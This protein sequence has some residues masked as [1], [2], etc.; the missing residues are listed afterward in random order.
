MTPPI[1]TVN[2]LTIAFGDAAPVVNGVSFTLLA[3]E[4]LG[5]LGLSGSGKSLTALALL[6]LLPAGAKVTAG[7]AL[8][9]LK[10]GSE[11]DLLQLDQGGWREI[12]GRDISLIFQEPLTALNPTQRVSRQLMEAIRQQC[13]ELTNPAVREEHLRSWLNRVELSEGQDRILGAYPHEL[14]GG[15]RQRLLIA[16]ALLS[17][18][19]L[20]IADEPTTALDTITEAGIIRLIAKLREELG[21]SL[22]FI[23]HDLG[24]IR[25][26]AERVLTLES[27]QVT[28]DGTTAEIL[29]LPN[30][31]LSSAKSARNQSPIEEE[32]ITDP[33]SEAGTA[34]SDLTATAAVKEYEVLNVE[35]L[36]INYVGK[37]IF[38]WSSPPSFAAVSGVSFSVQSSE[39]V[40]LVGPSGCGKTSVARHLAGLIPAAAGTVT[41]PGNPQLIFQ[42]PFSSLNPRFKVATTLGEVLRRQQP[43][44]NSQLLLQ[45][46][47]DLLQA[48]GLPAAEFMDRLPEQL[49]GGQRQRVAIARALAAQPK[50]LIADEAVSALDAPLRI[51]VLTLLNQ[52]RKTSG[53]G[54]LFISHDLDLVAEWADRVLIMDGGQIV[55][56]GKAKDIL[57]TPTSE[58]GKRLVAATSH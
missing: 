38:P 30:A 53:F 58:M 44:P 40:A 19:R 35:D 5:F 20:L 2:D 57:G 39:W 3:G 26:T 51:E 47:K 23:T 31:G 8:Y 50:L 16:L 43:R 4:Q 18:P 27:G 52:L 34:S 1:L 33:F 41:Y 14:S 11:V 46:T 32:D 37:K 6:G 9:R 22:I 36:R 45:Q 42:D 48:V 10:N 25:R 49:S 28:Q 29:A 17:E 12:R 56:A 15:Q 54:L 24:V 55:E 21:M 13:P 7:T